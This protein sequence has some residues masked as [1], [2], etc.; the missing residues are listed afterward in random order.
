MFFVY[1][2]QSLKDQKFYTGFTSN[3]EKRI[4]AHNN[5]EVQST[6]YRIPLKLIFYEAY[7]N[8][9]DAIR[10]EDYLKTAKGKRTLKMMLHEYL[11]EGTP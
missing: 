6:K 2:L 3:L 4:E 11:H 9:K 10:R 8:E 1:V 7:L 5:R